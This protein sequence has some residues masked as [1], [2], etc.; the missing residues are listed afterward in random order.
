VKARSI[1]GGAESTR[2]DS[3]SRESSCAVCVDDVSSRLEFCVTL[4]TIKIMI[5]VLS[6]NLKES[7][8][9]LPRGGQMCSSFV[10]GTGRLT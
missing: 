8:S 3:R 6:K 1:Q 9:M 4:N 2:P 7:Y 10:S 5:V